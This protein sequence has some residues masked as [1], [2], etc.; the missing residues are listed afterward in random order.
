LDPSTPVSDDP[1]R[2]SV[3][4]GPSGPDRGLV[5]GT[6][7]AAHRATL[8]I[9]RNRIFKDFPGASSTAW[10]RTPKFADVAGKTILPGLIDLHT[11]LT[12]PL[13]EGD[14]QHAPSE[15]DATLRAVEKLRYFFESGITGV[16]DVASQGDVTFRLKEWVR[17][18]RL[19]SSGRWKLE[20]TTVEHLMPRTDETIQFMAKKGV[21]ADTTLIPH[22]IIFDEWGG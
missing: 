7:A 4:P 2:I 5:D 1:R 21:A 19:A 22:E 15:A 11:H 9:A 16:R 10:P 8:V 6:E 18:D 20:R 13:T 3:K 12:Y 17:E 14:A